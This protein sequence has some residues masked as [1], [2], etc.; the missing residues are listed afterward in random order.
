MNKF[1]FLLALLFVA[2]LIGADGGK[3][4]QLIG[5]AGGSCMNLPEHEGAAPRH[6]GAAVSLPGDL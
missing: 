2:A 6:T 4:A 3:A 1:A 5:G